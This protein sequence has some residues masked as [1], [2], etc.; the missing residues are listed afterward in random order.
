[1][2]ALVLLLLAVPV[3]AQVK[4]WPPYYPRGENVSYSVLEVD[5]AY[6]GINITDLM[7]NLSKISI[8][9]WT[10]KDTVGIALLRNSAWTVTFSSSA[11]VSVAGGLRPPAFIVQNVAAGANKSWQMF[12]DFNGNNGMTVM[13][14]WFYSHYRFGAA[15]LS[16]TTAPKAGQ[17]FGIQIGT[18]A[19]G[20]SAGGGTAPAWPASPC[21]PYARLGIK[22]ATGKIVLDIGVG[23][24][25]KTPLV[26]DVGDAL[27]YPGGEY[28]P[29]DELYAPYL[30][31]DWNP[32][33]PSLSAYVN[34][35]LV[36]A[37]TDTAYMPK[38]GQNDQASYPTETGSAY[39]PAAGLFAETGSEA[40]STVVGVWAYPQRMQFH[41]ATLG[42][43]AKVPKVTSFE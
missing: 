32:Y 14:L 9:S 33:V 21:S 11:D 24:Q 8:Q 27:T 41:P 10:L 34:H 1:M 13:N 40:T 22:P 25:I 5:T 38:W 15:V 6:G 42:G 29:N 16:N 12:L 19:A 7:N 35:V 30:E 37:L 18:P 26:V 23:D 39:Q 20:S 4:G 17:F 31:L 43:G 28:T 3:K 2:G 36:Y